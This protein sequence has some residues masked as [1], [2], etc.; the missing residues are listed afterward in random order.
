LIRIRI[1]R[2]GGYCGVMAITQNVFP[3][4]WPAPGFKRDGCS[5]TD[6]AAKARN[7]YPDLWDAY[8]DH[9]V[10]KSDDFDQLVAAEMRKGVSREIAGQRVIT[11]YGVRPD[12]T[13]V[14]KHEASAAAFTVAVATLMVEKRCSRTA[15]MAEIRKRRPDLYE[16]FQED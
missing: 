13:R 7:E 2:A 8:R 5:R 15:A 16:S 11:K 6:A 3:P 1:I 10:S 4:G 14:D 12:A 9:T